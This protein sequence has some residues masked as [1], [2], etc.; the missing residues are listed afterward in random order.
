MCRWCEP[1]QSQEQG[2]VPSRFAMFTFTSFLKVGHGRGD[3]S[4]IYIFHKHLF[5]L[6]YLDYP[7]HSK[8][9]TVANIVCDL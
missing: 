9:V 5:N 1:Y 3:V 8:S 2:V 4:I 7:C 6:N